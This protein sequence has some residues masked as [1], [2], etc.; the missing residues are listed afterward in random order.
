MRVWAAVA[1]LLVLVGCSVPTLAC[2]DIGSVSGISVTVLAPYAAQ[3][4]AVRLKVCWAE[5]CQERDVELTPGSD[6]IDQGCSGPE[7]DDTCS[8]TAVPNG[9]KVGFAE[10]SELPA[11]PITVAATVTLDGRRVTAA[12]AART[13]ETSYPNGPQ[14]GAG[15]N[16]AQI[17]IDRT[18]IR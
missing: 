9:T 12:E 2:T 4:D 16:Q 13:A 10:L 15:G 17:E 18:G 11:G 5:N 1:P 7:P 6:T 8:A 3:V 14:C